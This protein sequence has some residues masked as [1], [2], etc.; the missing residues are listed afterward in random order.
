MKNVGAPSV[1]VSNILTK[2]T[3]DIICGKNYYLLFR[4][5]LQNKVNCYAFQE[6]KYCRPIHDMK[7]LTFLFKF[8][9]I[10]KHL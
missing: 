2:C 4:L 3:L 5:L 6:N 1:N 10:Y 9:T 7:Y 8:H